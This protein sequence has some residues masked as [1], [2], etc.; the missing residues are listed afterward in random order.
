[1]FVDMVLKLLGEDVSQY[2]N[3]SDKW[4]DVFTGIWGYSTVYLSYILAIIPWVWI[5]WH[6]KRGGLVTKKKITVI[7]VI[8]LLLFLL[9]YNLPWWIIEIIGGLAVRS[10]YGGQI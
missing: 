9:G 8:S 3:N 10:L 7:A 1:M 6:K 4:L 2:Q 5:L